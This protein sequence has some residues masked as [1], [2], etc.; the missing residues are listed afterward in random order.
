MLD[1]TVE[2]LAVRPGRMPPCVAVVMG[3]AS[4]WPTMQQAVEVLER[5]G[6]AHEAHVVSAHRMP[7]EMFAFAESAA[8]RGLRAI[9][10]GAGGAAHLPGMLAAKTTVPVLGV[11]VRVEAPPRAGLAALDRADAGRRPG[12][13]VRDRRGRGDERRPVRRRPARPTTT[14]RCAPPSRRTAPS[15]AS[16]RRGRRWRRDADVSAAPGADRPTGDDR[17]ARRRPAR[18]LRPRRRPAR[19]LPH[20]RPR[21]RPRRPRRT[22]SPTSIS[23]PPYDDRGALDELAADCAVVTTEFENP[24]ASALL[25]LAR[26]VVV[27]PPPAAVAIAQD[28]VAEKSF[29]AARRHRPS[30]RARRSPTTPTSTRPRRSATPAIVKTAR[31]GYDGKGQRAVDDP[32]G[33]A[34]AWD[35]LGRVPCVV[36]RRVRPRRRGQRRRRPH[37][38]TGRSPTVPARRER[39]PR[40]HP[41]PHRRAGPGRRRR[42]PPRRRRSPRRSPRRST[43]SACWRSSCS[44]SAGRLLVNELAPRPHNSGHWTLDAAQTEPVRPADPGDHRSGARRR[45]R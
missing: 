1:P 10:A 44:S 43:T 24:P 28:R 41:R 30:R 4:D 37:A 14:P 9:I 13:H 18:P 3:S 33:I 11:P 45:R 16:R 20:H 39:P 35:Q 19:R 26:D 23:S 12:R 8:G 32:D 42:S 31:L 7:D 5:F 22:R 34:A 15:D 17:H 2:A 40:R 21:S 6:V 38:P 25:R 36:E 29:L 27:A